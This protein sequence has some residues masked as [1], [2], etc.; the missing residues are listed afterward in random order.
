MKEVNVVKKL[1][2]LILVL[3]M[4][5]PLSAACTGPAG[6]AGAPGPAGPA[7]PAGA[8]GEPGTPA[9]TACIVIT[10]A[11]GPIKTT[12]TI[13]GA[14]FV[15]GETVELVLD[16]GGANN[17]LGTKGL[18]GPLVANEYG[19]FSVISRIPRVNPPAGTY[20]ME[21]RGNKGTIAFSPLEITE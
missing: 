19:A 8:A 11:S 7:G 20:A 12:I 15:P 5:V 3:V 6:L 10:P 2:V 4:L 16:I 21:A 1:M 14:G 13:S 18:G 9:S 17:L